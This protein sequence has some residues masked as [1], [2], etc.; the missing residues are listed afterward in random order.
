L[1]V[2]LIQIRKSSKCLN[3]YLKTRALRG[4]GGG[5][6]RIGRG[7]KKAGRSSLGGHFSGNAGALAIAR[8][9]RALR[10]RLSGGT[11]RVCL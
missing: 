11:W 2:R 5:A 10:M 8:N 4:T 1:S 3:P 9:R 7:G 6:G